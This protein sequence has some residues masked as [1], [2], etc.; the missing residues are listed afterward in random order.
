MGVPARVAERRL[1]TTTESCGPVL[2][3]LRRAHF[4]DH[5][6]GRGPVVAATGSSRSLI[7]KLA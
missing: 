4:F 5:N 7:D 6:S 3:L 1:V 2:P